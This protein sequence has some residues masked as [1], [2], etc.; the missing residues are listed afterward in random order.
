MGD[1]GDAQAALYSVGLYTKCDAV[2]LNY[3][4]A[5]LFCWNIN[6]GDA[7]L[8]TEY[9]G[10]TWEWRPQTLETEEIPTVRW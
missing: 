5:M 4:M 1:A 6:M 3:M 2:L 10:A 8:L 9:N 7:V